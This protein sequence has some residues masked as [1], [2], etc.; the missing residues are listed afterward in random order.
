MKKLGLVAAAAV[1]VL[2]LAGCQ[3]GVEEVKV[4]PDSQTSNYTF[5]VSGTATVTMAI[6]ET[7]TYNNKASD[8][9]KRGKTSKW[10]G[11]YK[12]EYTANDS[13]LADITWK[14]P[15]YDNSNRKDYD[16]SLSGLGMVKTYPDYDADGKQVTS[17]KTHKNESVNIRI[18]KIG[19]EYY[20]YNWWY[21]EDDEARFAGNAE[22][23]PIDETDLEDDEVVISFTRTY[24][25]TE[26]ED[27]TEGIDTVIAEKVTNT[28]YTVTYNY[29]LERL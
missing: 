27:V 2:A 13:S 20:V 17:T 18:T 6:A 3:N 24:T 22:L 15:Y 19:D 28:T 16:V 12:Q 29:T 1:A 9:D 8:P 21:K 10:E 4:V 11:V 23:I 14:T 26:K 25:S 7:T 5:D